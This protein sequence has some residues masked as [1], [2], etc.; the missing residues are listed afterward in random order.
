[1]N[2]FLTLIK[3][4]L[5]IHPDLINQKLSNF[6]YTQLIAYN[7]GND[8]VPFVVVDYL[9]D[10]WIKRNESNENL[11]TFVSDKHPYFCQFVNK[12][13]R[14]I[15]EETIKLYIPL[16]EVHLAEGA[17]R[18]FDFIAK[19]GIEHNSKI[20]KKIRNDNIV[21]RVAKVS[22]AEKII[23]YVMSDDYI[24]EGLLNTNP[25]TINIKG[26][27][28]AKDGYYSYNKELCHSI[29]RLIFI[30]NQKNRLDDLNVNS[31]KSY[32]EEVKDCGNDDLRIIN[33]LQRAVLSGRKLGIEDFK[34]II[35]NKSYELDKEQMFKIIVMETYLKYG[36]NHT[37]NAIAKYR[38]N[39]N[40][41]GFT[42]D[43]NARYMLIRNFTIDDV[44]EI[45]A[46]KNL[47]NDNIIKSYIESI[48]P[49]NDYDLIVAAYK[50]TL[51]KYGKEQAT[52]ALQE[53][54]L[55]GE[56]KYVTNDNHARDNLKKVN[57]FE[58]QN[59]LTDALNI[60][61]NFSSEKLFEVFISQMEEIKSY[62]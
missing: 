28:I 19:E 41:N 44:N 40:A 62:K 7:L 21:V 52:I 16:D 38:Y 29:A 2:D 59:I 32:L 6:I 31:L 43:N 24:Q 46:N 36:I 14:N 30:L 51:N 20:G 39:G 57:V 34:N 22:D 50:E 48:M 18:I 10:Y 49:K 55:H 13:A 35:A 60:T 3:T 37:I 17:N 4:Y 25:F 45:L 23:N 47:D 58:I 12:N 11:E 54:I 26:V 53:F 33:A 56:T 42:R 8:Q 15:A 9:F 61:E 27:G 1:M 5:K